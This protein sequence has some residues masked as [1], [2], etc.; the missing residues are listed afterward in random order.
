M[1]KLSATWCRPRIILRNREPT[2]LHVTYII[3]KELQGT[4]HPRFATIT[5]DGL[6]PRSF[7]KAM[8]YLV[9]LDPSSYYAAEKTRKAAWCWHAASDRR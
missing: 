1:E 4:Q 8:A 7:L 2:L 9:I 3:D 5:V 6:K